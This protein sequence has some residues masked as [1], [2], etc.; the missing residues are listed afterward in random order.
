ME[1]DLTGAKLG[2]VPDMAAPGRER[3]GEVGS[4]RF[5]DEGE[6][7]AAAPE[8]GEVGRDRNRNAQR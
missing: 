3:A 7:T 4:W 6:R 8:T 1:G 2:A 5:G